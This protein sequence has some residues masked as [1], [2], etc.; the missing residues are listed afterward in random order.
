M[1]V[2]AVM[3]VDFPCVR[4]S[5]LSRT[6]RSIFSIS[7][8][9]SITT[10]PSAVRRAAW[11]ANKSSRGTFPAT[12]FSSALVAMCDWS[13]AETYEVAVFGERGSIP[14]L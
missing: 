2:M 1:A 12:F 7:H 13:A 14:P 5:C 4:R 6:S 3:E 10:F 8:G 11:V 9:G